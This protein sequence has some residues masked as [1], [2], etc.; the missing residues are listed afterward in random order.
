MT[1]HHLPIVKYSK[2]HRPEFDRG[3]ESHGFWVS[4]A[5]NGSECAVKAPDRKAG[6]LLMGQRHPILTQQV[7]VQVILANPGL[8]G[9]PFIP[10]TA[11]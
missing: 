9:I 7:A 11:H 8:E 4:W 3:L 5:I 6:P 1:H 10:L 2:P